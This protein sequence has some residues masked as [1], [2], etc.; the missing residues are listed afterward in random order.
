[1][2]IPSRSFCMLI[3]SVAAA[4]SIRSFCSSVPRYVSSVK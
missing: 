4:K 2:M 3:R 1:M